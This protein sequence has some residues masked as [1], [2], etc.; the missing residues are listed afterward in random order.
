MKSGNEIEIVV[1]S[2]QLSVQESVDES[3]VFQLSAQES[4][5]R[6]IAVV[7]ASGF[8]V[9][10]GASDGTVGVPELSG[11]AGESDG[12]PEVP[13]L[14]GVDVVGPPEGVP[15]LSGVVTEASDGI[16]EVPELFGVKSVVGASEGTVG[17]LSTTSVVVVRIGV[18]VVSVVLVVVVLG[19]CH[20]HLW[21]LADSSNV[22]AFYYVNIVCDETNKNAPK[23]C[24]D[25]I[26]HNNLRKNTYFID[27]EHFPN[28]ILVIW[29]LLSLADSLNTEWKVLCLSSVPIFFQLR[30]CF[31]N[32]TFINTVTFWSQTSE[33]WATKAN[34]GNS[35]SII[36]TIRSGLSQSSW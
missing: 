3:V 13:E 34:N 31:H 10:L 16:P 11:V 1:I 20:G 5:V 2:S 6:S 26:S 30:F 17:V 22:A 15:E 29:N 23:N 19:L 36:K 33:V 14:F 7:V 9:V 28:F 4:V 35:N 21:A 25:R 24:L 27:F 18:V 32:L 8:F 12:D